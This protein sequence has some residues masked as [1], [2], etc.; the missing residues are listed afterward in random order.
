MN[1]A[2][3][4]LCALAARQEPPAPPAS[5]AQP[6]PN[7]AGARDAGWKLLE[8]VEIVVNEDIVTTSMLS[9]E[10]VRR[11]KELNLQSERE[12]AELFMSI[13]DEILRRMVRTQAGE[14]LGFD[15]AQ[16][17]RIVRNEFE[18]AVDLHGGMTGFS[19]WLEGLGL[20]AEE[21]KDAR[22]DHIHG[23]LWGDSVTGRG[24]SATTASRPSRDRYVR[25]G[26]LRFEHENLVNNP[27][28]LEALGGQAEML[29]IRRL[30]L[31][32]PTPADEARVHALALELRTRILDGEDM[33]K[34]VEEHAYPQTRGE[35]SLIRTSPEALARALPEVAAFAARARIDEVSDVLP[36][37]IGKERFFVLNRLEEHT[38]GS[39]PPLEDVQT[40]SKLAEL[41]QT[42]LDDS[43]VELALQRAFERSYTWSAKRPGAP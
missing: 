4:L 12:K 28:R 37:A 33:A 30:I 20:T 7:A 2:L 41:I 15:P 17:E 1:L 31:Q 6:A 14:T 40:Q 16:I 38:S 24:A 35:A 43:R 25:P 27:R 10:F 22:R 11:A 5:P 18:R 34:L 32:V 9:R 21:W 23:R 39:I 26:L 19:M 42:D 13:Q 8:R 3:A 29:R 36:V